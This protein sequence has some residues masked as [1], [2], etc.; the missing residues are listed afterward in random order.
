MPLTT[1]Y[2]RANVDGS[3]DTF[4]KVYMALISTALSV[5]AESVTAANH[6]ARS[7]YALRVL[8]DPYGFTKLMLPAFTVDGALDI[9]TATDAQ[10]ETRAS[11]IFN[12]YCVQG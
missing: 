10:I 3:T 1:D 8:A 2:D 7:A 6:A 11:S 9:T 5:Q 12:A 4:K